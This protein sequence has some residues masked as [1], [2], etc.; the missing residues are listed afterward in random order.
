MNDRVLRTAS[1]L[2][3]PFAIVYGSYVTVYGHLSPGGG[4][5]GGALLAATVVLYTLTWG[6]NPRTLRR[7]YRASERMESGALLL[8]IAIGVVGIYRG[9]HFLTNLDAGIPAG[10]FGAVLSAGFIPIIGIAIGIK[11]ANTVIRLFHAMIEDRT[12]AS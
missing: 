10:E 5:P 3:I 4:F 8:F 11:V 2:I 9:K 12:D 6:G 7:S 1:R